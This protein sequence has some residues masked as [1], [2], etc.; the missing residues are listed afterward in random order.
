VDNV[1]KLRATQNGHFPL[2]IHFPLI[3]SFLKNKFNSKFDDSVESH[4]AG[5]WSDQ[6]DGVM[7]ANFL[8]S[9]EICFGVVDVTTP[10]IIGRYRSLSPAT[11]LNGAAFCRVS[12]F[13]LTP[14]TRMWQ[15]SIFLKNNSN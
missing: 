6:S 9:F 10:E 3:S 15:C 14:L 5:I 8:E 2:K 13:T 4:P 1:R 11:A 7:G 12:L